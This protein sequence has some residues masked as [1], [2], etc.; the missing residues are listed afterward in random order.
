[1]YAAGL[2]VPRDYVASYMWYKI[3]SENG[4]EQA[5]EHQT[6]A[7]LMRPGQVTEAKRRARICIESDFKD[8]D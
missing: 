8:C 6:I 1:M 7:T 3:A 5:T 4:L 2:G